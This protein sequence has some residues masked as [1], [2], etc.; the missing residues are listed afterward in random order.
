MPYDKG[1]KYHRKPVFKANLK[2]SFSR[3]RKN[4]KNS[5]II[6]PITSSPSD[7]DIRVHDNWRSWHQ[8]TIQKC[9]ATDIKGY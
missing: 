1:R 2:Y 6:G 7:R 4:N 9:I 5:K 3:K 8:Q